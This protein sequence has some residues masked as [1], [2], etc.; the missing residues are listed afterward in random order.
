MPR[1]RVLGLL[2]ENVDGLADVVE[3]RGLRE[4]G[5]VV[6][7]RVANDLEVGT[8]VAVEQRAAARATLRAVPVSCVLSIGPSRPGNPC[9]GNGHGGESHRVLTHR[10]VPPCTSD[11]YGF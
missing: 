3:M 1:L 8:G 11:A 7:R 9:Q 10:F 6:T 4:L 5:R 2:A